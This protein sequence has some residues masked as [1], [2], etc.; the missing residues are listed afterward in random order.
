MSSRA[1]HPLR[2]GANV[3]SLPHTS[4]VKNLKELIALA[5]AKPGPLTF[6]TSGVGSSNHMSGE[7]LK[8]MAG[9]DIV[10]VPYEGT[11]RRI[12]GEVAFGED[13]IDP[14][15]AASCRL[16]SSFPPTIA[17]GTNDI[18]RNIIAKRVPGLR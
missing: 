6:G 10:H 17:S 12:E 3:L 15:G 4:S 14:M 11:R 2:T 7:L 9:T 5:K 8:M 16:M 13:L 18:Q 1:D